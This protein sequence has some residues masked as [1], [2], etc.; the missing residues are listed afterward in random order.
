MLTAYLKMELGI[1]VVAYGSP[2]EDEN[3]D[4]TSRDS[5][6][7]NVTLT[8]CSY[9]KYN[10]VKLKFE[11]SALDSSDASINIENIRFILRYKAD[12]LRNS[13]IRNN[14]GHDE[15]VDLNSTILDLLSGGDDVVLG[16]DLR[17]GIRRLDGGG[18]SEIDD[19]GD[20]YRTPLGKLKITYSIEDID[21]DSLSQ[22]SITST[23]TINN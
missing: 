7:F 16:L 6:V 14:P 19:N 8:P 2:N 11:F 3:I 22:S 10:T 23:A 18:L 20:L 21:T 15:I 13:F 9:L 5:Q 4:I 12:M 1:S 17:T